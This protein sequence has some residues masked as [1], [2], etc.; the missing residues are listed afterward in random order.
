MI[1]YTIS[2]LLGSL[3]PTHFDAQEKCHQE[4]VI[5]AFKTMQDIQDNV[6]VN[7]STITTV[8]ILKGINS[9][10]GTENEEQNQVLLE[11]IDNLL[12]DLENKKN[13]TN[14]LEKSQLKYIQLKEKQKT[15]NKK[16]KAIQH[17]YLNFIQEQEKL[18]VFFKEERDKYLLCNS[19]N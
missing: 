10:P 5:L 4:I 8:S 15:I 14:Q 19:L 6:Y 16:V 18:I 3:L 9:T 7:D 1:L 13:Y 2:S 11:V 12:D 17:K